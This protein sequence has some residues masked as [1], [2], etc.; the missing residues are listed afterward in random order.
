M[1]ILSLLLTVV[2]VGSNLHAVAALVLGVRAKDAAD[3]AR[4]ARRCGWSAAATT[5]L[6]LGGFALAFAIGGVPRGE[7]PVDRA[8]HL[9]ALISETINCAAFALLAALLPVVVAVVLT[10]R[11]ARRAR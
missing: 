2:A 7:D 3:V 4:H 1:E 5:L 8:S 10:R 11:A 6:A 9:A